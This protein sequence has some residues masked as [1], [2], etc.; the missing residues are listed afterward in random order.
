[1]DK[2]DKISYWLNLADKDLK[3]ADLCFAGELFLHSAYHCHQVV[4]KLFKAAYVEINEIAP[5]FIHHLVKLSK[6]AGLYDDFTEAQ[7]VFLRDLNPMNLEARYPHEIE[8]IENL[9]DKKQCEY[10]VSRTREMSEWI[11]N[12]LLR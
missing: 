3:A 11:K 6:K 10:F 1:M 12:K 9:L 2:K 8:A 7:I 4:E 5:P